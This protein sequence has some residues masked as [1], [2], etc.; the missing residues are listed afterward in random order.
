MNECLKI[1]LA[2]LIVAVVGYPLVTL[3]DKW[4]KEMEAEDEKGG[5]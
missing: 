5:E 2:V 4:K 1:A 3:F